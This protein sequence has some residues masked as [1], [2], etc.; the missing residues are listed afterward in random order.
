[1]HPDAAGLATHSRHTN[2]RP[3]RATCRP[4]GTK[5]ERTACNGSAREANRLV[6]GVSRKRLARARTTTARTTNR[7]VSSLVRA[8]LSRIRGQVIDAMQHESAVPEG[9]HPFVKLRTVCMA[10]C[11]FLC[12]VGASGSATSMSLS[13]RK[14]A[15]PMTASVVSSSSGEREHSMLMA[16]RSIAARQPVRA[17]L[18]QVSSSSL[19]CECRY[20]GLRQRFSCLDAFRARIIPEWGCRRGGQRSPRSPLHTL[21]CTI[22][23]TIVLGE[24]ASRPRRKHL[25]SSSRVYTSIKDVATRQFRIRAHFCKAGESGHGSHV[26]AAYSVRVDSANQGTRG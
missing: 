11:T 7:R 12:T 21:T 18:Q 10:V 26:R 14:T 24:S 13:S 1:M 16:A 6:A 9:H 23:H 19:S 2:Y 3:S 4:C 15:V 22:I 5:C 8:V 20:I 17:P 25:A